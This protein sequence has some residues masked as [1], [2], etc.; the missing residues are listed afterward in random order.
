MYFLIQVYKKLI[1]K[2]FFFYATT[3]TSR[4][5]G[6]VVLQ[7]YY[8]NDKLYLVQYVFTCLVLS[9]LFGSYCQN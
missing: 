5:C 7:V 1:E 8:D 2:L 6:E 3:T 9:T 4:D